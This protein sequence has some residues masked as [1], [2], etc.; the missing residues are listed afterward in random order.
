MRSE[1]IKRHTG[2]KPKTKF[3]E[4]IR[5][6][7]NWYKNN[8]QIWEKIKRSQEFEEHKKRI[9]GDLF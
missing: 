6:T 2:F 9:Y 8:R 7:I 5:K 1:K 4:G 3:K